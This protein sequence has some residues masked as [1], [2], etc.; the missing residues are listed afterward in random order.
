MCEYFE[1][2]SFEGGGEVKGCKK[3]V[4]TDISA[5]KYMVVNFQQGFPVKVSSCMLIVLDRTSS[6][7]SYAPR[8]SSLLAFQ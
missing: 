8:I 4:F 6:T 5:A 3:N 1:I 7:H 2:N